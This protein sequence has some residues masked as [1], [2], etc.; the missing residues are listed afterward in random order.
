MFVVIFIYAFSGIVEAG[1]LGLWIALILTRGVFNTEDSMLANEGEPFYLKI[2]AL[3]VCGMYVLFNLV[4]C[5]LYCAVTRF[6]RKY[7]VW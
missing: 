7:A 6:D 4:G 5:I 3:A 1:S 2:A